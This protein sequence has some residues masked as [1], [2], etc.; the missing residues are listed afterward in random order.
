MLLY[1]F[2]MYLLCTLYHCVMAVWAYAS[3][4]LKRHIVI[5]LCGQMT[6]L[7][8]ALSRS[9]VITMYVVDR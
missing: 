1:N 7:L 2:A 8:C 4:F 9:C 3:A 6:S 5:A